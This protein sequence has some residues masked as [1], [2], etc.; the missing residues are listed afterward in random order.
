LAEFEAI[1]QM[2][3]NV[4]T[5]SEIFFLFKSK[6][7]REISKVYSFLKS[8][9]NSDKISIQIQSSYDKDFIER[10]KNIL[11]NVSLVQ[12]I[13]ME[14]LSETQN[15]INL[16]NNDKNIDY[17]LLDTDQSGGT[18]KYLGIDPILK[19]VAIITKPF[20]VAGG[21]SEHNIQNI[22]KHLES[23]SIKNFVGFDLESSLEFSEKIIYVDNNG[24]YIKLRKDPKKI[25]NLINKLNGK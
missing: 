6:S 1:Q 3:K 20:W 11:P 14:E 17:I 9:C 19:S 2:L 18:G 7:V 15:K 24:T 21:I 12:M 25:I 10:L 22:K 13:S 4:S 5:N 23:L 8:I 16:V